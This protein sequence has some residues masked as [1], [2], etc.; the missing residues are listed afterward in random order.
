MAVDP[1]HGVVPMIRS[2]LRRPTPDVITAAVVRVVVVVAEEEE[3]ETGMIPRETQTMWVDAVLPGITATTRT[4]T[5]TLAI[6]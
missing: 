4:R 5:T 3:E 6:T 1:Q 2:G